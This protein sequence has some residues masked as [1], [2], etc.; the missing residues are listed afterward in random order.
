M[1]SLVYPDLV[2]L[3]HVQGSCHTDGAPSTTVCLSSDVF[4]AFC[5]LVTFSDL[6]GKRKEAATYMEQVQVLRSNDVLVAFLL[7]CHLPI[8]TLC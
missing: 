6:F 2:T 5:T 1:L 4:L 8:A 3:G 7:P